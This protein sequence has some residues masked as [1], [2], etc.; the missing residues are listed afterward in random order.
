[1]AEIELKPVE[2]SRLA[3]PCIFR[4]TMSVARRIACMQDFVRQMLPLQYCFGVG[5]SRS[6]QLFCPCTVHLGASI[7]DRHAMSD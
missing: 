7:S 2:V 1:M 4:A 5:V 3:E 6:D